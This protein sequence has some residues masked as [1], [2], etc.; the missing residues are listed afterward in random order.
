MPSQMQQINRGLKN[1]SNAQEEKGKASVRKIFSEGEKSETATR[2][3]KKKVRR[4]A[5]R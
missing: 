5:F 2:K 4:C 3:K 1:P